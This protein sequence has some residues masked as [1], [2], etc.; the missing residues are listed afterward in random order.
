MPPKDKRSHVTIV[1]RRSAGGNATP[2]NVK[3]VRTTRGR[4]STGRTITERSSEPGDHAGVHVRRERRRQGGPPKLLTSRSF[5]QAKPIPSNPLIAVS[6]PVW[7]TPRALFE[8]ALSSILNQTHTNVVVL[9][10]SDGEKRPSYAGSKLIEDPRVVTYHSPTNYGPYFHHHLAW[11]ASG[12]PLFAVQDSDDASGSTRFEELLAAMRKHRAD[13]AFPSV[14]EHRVGGRTSTVFPDSAAVGPALRHPLDHFW[15]VR[16]DLIE[17][18]GGYYTGTRMGAD[19]L[20]TSMAVKLGRCVG[21]PDAKYHRYSREDSLTQHANTGHR[22]AQRAEA[23]KKLQGLWTQA[24]SMSQPSQTQALLK[25]ARG[26]ERDR[27]LAKAI[28]HLRP[29]MAAAV[30]AAA[31]KSAAQAPVSAP[32]DLHR[33]LSAAK[34]TDW[35]ITRE[36]AIALYREVVRL[37]SRSIIDFGSGVSTLVFA[38]HAKQTGAKVV[39]LEADKKWLDITA[40]SLRQLGLAEYV[41]LIHAPLKDATRYKIARAT[42]HFDFGVGAP[43][44]FVFIDGPPE[45]VGRHGT[46]PSI[47]AHLDTEWHAWVHDGARPGERQ[48]VSLWSKHLP[49]D[50][51]SQLSF[52]EDKRGVLK[53]ASQ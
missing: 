28:E 29:Q 23:K 15:L 33:V 1:R 25:N 27:A 24:R 19:S 42:Y 35:S 45:R 4:G 8:R 17:A 11:A 30:A 43:Y 12:A 47:A 7:N 50:F 51:S 49:V 53:L 6:L 38:L 20:L 14:V 32:G 48:C 36:C 16:S 5:I 39:S 46:L 18:L 41:T 21:V 52:A 37:K 13:A 22:S 10:A 31:K 26:P 2:T 3:S 40:A 44:D 9:V 34:F